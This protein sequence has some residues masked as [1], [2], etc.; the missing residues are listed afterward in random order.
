MASKIAENNELHCSVLSL[1]TICTNAVRVFQFKYALHRLVHEHTWTNFGDIT[2]TTH[3]PTAII[4][5]H[6][7]WYSFVSTLTHFLNRNEEQAENMSTPY[8]P[9]NIDDDYTNL[10]AGS[11]T[12]D[13]ASFSNLDSSRY[14]PQSIKSDVAHLGIHLQPLDLL[15]TTSTHN[16]DL[17]LQR[18]SRLGFDPLS[19]WA[20]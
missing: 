10:W 3:S 15:S 8:D 9:Q 18:N 17:T 7:C 2:I 19:D 4:I 5:L 16:I 1:F 13:T 12:F 20:A 6:L 14:L 11:T